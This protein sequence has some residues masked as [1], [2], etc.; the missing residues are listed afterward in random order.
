[1]SSYNLNSCQLYVILTTGS[2]TLNGFLRS[3]NSK[4]EA[5]NSFFDNVKMVHLVSTEMQ[6][7]SYDVAIDRVIYKLFSHY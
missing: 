2:Q 1:M 4:L 3:L 5:L 6:S 7:G